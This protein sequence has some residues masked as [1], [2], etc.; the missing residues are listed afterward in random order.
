[1][2][3][4]ELAS[5]IRIPL[6]N[7]EQE[8]VEKLLEDDDYILSEREIVIAQTLANKD[9]L[10]KEELENGESNFGINYHVDVWRD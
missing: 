7:E 5:G 9:I 3:V 4:W 10:I 8:L 6:C 2:K 1:M